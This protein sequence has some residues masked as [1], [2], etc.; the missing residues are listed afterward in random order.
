MGTTANFLYFTRYLNKPNCMFC[1]DR[2]KRKQAPGKPTTGSTVPMSGSCVLAKIIEIYPFFDC[3]L[4][5]A[6]TDGDGDGDG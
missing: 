1:I 6:T 2:S 5:A 3:F 4:T